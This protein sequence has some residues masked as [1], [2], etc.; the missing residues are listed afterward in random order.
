MNKMLEIINCNVSIDELSPASL[1][2]VGDACFEIYVRSKITLEENRKI[3]DLN[4]EAMKYVKA[5]MQAES[6]KDIESFLTEE[7][8]EIYKRGRNHKGSISSKSAT[9]AD[10]RMATGLECLIGY[11]FLKNENDRLNELMKIIFDKKDERKNM[12][13][14]Q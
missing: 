12:N 8:L 2:Y 1:A 7:E 9:V 5:S 4:K 10:Y 6:Y 13:E 11:L 14:E 3:K